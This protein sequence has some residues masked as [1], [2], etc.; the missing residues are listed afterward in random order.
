MPKGKR[1]VH[2]TLDP[3][4]INKDIVADLALVGDAGLTLDA[5][6]ARG[7]GPAQG[8]ARAAAL[9]AVT[10]EISHAQAASGWPSGC[11]G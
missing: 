7:E 10:K 8:Q 4:D 3:L 6:I 1:I 11:R 9:G 2:A 5:L